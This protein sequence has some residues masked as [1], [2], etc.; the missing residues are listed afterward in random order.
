MVSRVSRTGLC[1]CQK[2]RE[3]QP[4]WP[5]WRNMSLGWEGITH[6]SYGWVCQHLGSGEY[7]PGFL[8][9]SG[10][11]PLLPLPWKQLPPTTRV[12]LYNHFSLLFSLKINTI[13]NIPHSHFFTSMKSKHREMLPRN[14]VLDLR[15][16]KNPFLYAPK[17]LR[18]VLSELGSAKPGSNAT[19][20]DSS[21]TSSLCRRTCAAFAVQPGSEPKS[22]WA[23]DEWEEWDGLMGPSSPASA[24]R[25]LWLHHTIL[26]NLGLHRQEGVGQD[27]SQVGFIKSQGQHLFHENTSTARS[28][29]S[30]LLCTERPRIGKDAWTFLLPSGLLTK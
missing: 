24:G 10:H 28:T 7:F 29:L 30:W 15:K 23:G 1:W 26:S 6:P 11:S 12:S 25:I 4:K 13:K 27:S 9:N 14:K 17:A 2:I 16:G 19:I 8:S 20:L 18:E 22:R 3:S 5:D 21:L